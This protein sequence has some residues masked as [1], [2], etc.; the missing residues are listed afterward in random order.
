[1]GHPRAYFAGNDVLLHSTVRCQ[2]PMRIRNDLN[3]MTQLRNM[4]VAVGENTYQTILYTDFVETTAP[5]DLMTSVV[6]MV[7]I[8]SNTDRLTD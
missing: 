3:L 2:K 5:F 7:M 6:D 1:M 4:P 8:S